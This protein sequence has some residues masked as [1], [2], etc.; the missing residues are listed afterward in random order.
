M[1]QFYLPVKEIHSI[2]RWVVLALA[3]VTI[4]KYLMGWMSKSSFKSLDNRLSLF[5]VSSL[6]L[7]LLIGLFL[8][9]FL[10][11]VTQSVMQ[12]GNAQ[13]ADANARF[14]AIEHPAAMLLGIIC[15]HI[16]RVACKKATTDA[17]R[18]KRG[19]IWFTLSLIL[20]LARMPW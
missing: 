20:I 10:S 3:L 12:L 19:A 14:F 16:G 9:F 13:L 2:L 8:Y 11:P 7:Q 5:Y 4:V 15:A 1:E 6:D 18:F 17:S